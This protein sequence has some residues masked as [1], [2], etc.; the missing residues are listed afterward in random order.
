MTNQDKTAD[1]IEISAKDSLIVSVILVI[2]FYLLALILGTTISVVGL[3][4][5]CCTGG[6]FVDSEYFNYLLFILLVTLLLFIPVI[7]FKANAIRLLNSTYGFVKPQI[8]VSQILR[9]MVTY[10]IIIIAL[11]LSDFIPDNLKYDQIGDLTKIYFPASLNSFIL[12]VITIGMILP[13]A[14]E[15]F[16][17]LIYHGFE[18][19][20]SIVKSALLSSLVFTVVDVKISSIFF[21][22]FSSIAYIHIYK[23][24]RSLW[25]PI[26]VHSTVNISAAVIAFT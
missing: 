5:V 21:I 26:C 6:W 23:Y 2:G 7:Y 12:S 4:Y 17:A 18:T 19:H 14:E 15:F 22:F 10:F 24:S 20:F 9:Y 1:Q 16:R 25:P 13:I 3:R 11:I 8:D